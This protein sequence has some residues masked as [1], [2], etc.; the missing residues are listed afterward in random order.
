MGFRNYVGR[1][2][3]LLALA[4]AVGIAVALMSGDERARTVQPNTSSIEHRLAQ[5]GAAFAPDR[6]A[7]FL[8]P[9]RAALA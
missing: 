5:R 7:P 9:A 3:L 4:L 8:R 2:L 1:T 6:P